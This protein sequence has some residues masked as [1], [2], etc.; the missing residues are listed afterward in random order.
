MLH[1]LNSMYVDKYL[2]KADAF[3]CIWLPT[4]CKAV[5]EE[6]S[7]FWN[8]NSDSLCT[9]SLNGYTTE[10]Q[11][12][13]FIISESICDVASFMDIILQGKLH[14]TGLFIGQLMMNSLV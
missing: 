10:I 14:A 2:V 11:E 9:I 5:K 6:M 7:L 1:S 4:L 3:T 8:K 13:V 12:E